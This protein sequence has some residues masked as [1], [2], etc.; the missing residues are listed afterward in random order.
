M[1]YQYYWTN[2]VRIIVVVGVVS[3]WRDISGRTG[4]NGDWGRLQREK[5]KYTRLGSDVFFL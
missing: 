5:E 3:R 4:W 1:T 2:L